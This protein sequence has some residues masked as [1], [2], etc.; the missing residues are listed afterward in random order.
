MLRDDP[1]TLT[2]TLLPSRELVMY[3]FVLIVLNRRRQMA[4]YI[5]IWESRGNLKG[6]Y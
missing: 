3:E 6:F 1:F 2:H 5:S 4:Q